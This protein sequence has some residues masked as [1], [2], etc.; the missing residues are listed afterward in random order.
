[1]KRPPCAS[2]PEGLAQRVVPRGAPRSAPTARARLVLEVGPR[3]RA[4]R[5]RRAADVQLLDDRDLG[6]RRQ[7]AALALGVVE[8]DLALELGELRVRVEQPGVGETR[9]TQ[10][11]LVVVRGQPDRRS[12][13]LRRPQPKLLFVEAEP[14]PLRRS[15]PGPRAALARPRASAR[16]RAGA[17]PEVRTRRSPPAGSRARARA[18]SG[19]R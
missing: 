5:R 10:H 9:G 17:A 15:R 7:A 6:R 1:M 3:P 16:T 11:G 12:R 18:R 8:A 13:G 4:S 19:H 14:V 2:R